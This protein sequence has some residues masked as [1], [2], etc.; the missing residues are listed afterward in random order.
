MPHGYSI[1]DDQDLQNSILHLESLSAAKEYI[2]LP[3][4]SYQVGDLALYSDD[5]VYR[6]TQDHIVNSLNGPGDL[7]FWEEVGPKVNFHSDTE[8]VNLN[9]F[10]NVQLW[11][12]NYSK[13]DKTVFQ[14]EN[15]VFRPT[16]INPFSLLCYSNPQNDPRNISRQRL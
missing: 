3:D 14:R 10:E 7:N 1:Y 4:F 8:T 13:F 2:A 5:N 15:R 16:A 11:G 12:F 6:A 9:F